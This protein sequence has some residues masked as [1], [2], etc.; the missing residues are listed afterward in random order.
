LR[1]GVLTGG[2][3]CAGLN[4]AILGVAKRAWSLQD[5]VYGIGKG[6][7][8]LMGE[9]EVYP[10]GKEDVVG[11]ITES[12]TILRTSR[13][14]PAKIE[15]G[16]DQA[17][18]TL[19]RNSIGGLVAIGGDDTLGVS[20]KLHERGFDV[21]GVPKTID[22]DLPSTDFCIGFDTAANV[23]AEEIYRLQTTARSHG[24]ILV[25]EVMGRE[26][27]WLSIVGGTAGGADFI[28][29]PEVPVHIDEL[30]ACAGQCG[31]TQGF[32][33]MA[34]AE[35]AEVDG[36][37]SPTDEQ[38][39][40]DAFGHVR[41]ADRGVAQQVAEEIERRTGIET[42]FA[43]LGHVQRGGTPTVHDRYV[44]MLLGGAAVDYLHRGLGGNM[45]AYK[46]QEI[47]PVPLAEV[48]GK[49][50]LVTPEIYETVSRYFRTTPAS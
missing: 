28:A 49:N 21:V 45:T 3:D 29:I 4:A 46:G 47:V 32:G 18:A 35:G 30:V 19:K 26:A 6:W 1:I 8:G 43:V 33:V 27:G 23:V 24:R 12:G 5:E 11:I 7:A 14:N 50:S 15:G 25:V 36:L 38:G 40:V 42:R 20:A 22:N 48:A 9:G 44:S 10:L 13:T 2:G 31:K 41:L 34:I 16:F 39:T 37:E 17:L